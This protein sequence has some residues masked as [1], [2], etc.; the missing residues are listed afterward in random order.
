MVRFTIKD[1]LLR[2]V[3]ME[4]LLLH[5]CVEVCQNEL[6]QQ[7]LMFNL[8]YLCF[9]VFYQGMYLVSNAGLYKVIIN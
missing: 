9:F 7:P 5:F 3:L 1:N 2:Y 4:D 6:I 8:M